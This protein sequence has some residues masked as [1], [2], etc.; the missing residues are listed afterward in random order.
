MDNTEKIKTKDL[1]I[2]PNFVGPRWIRDATFFFP[3]TY[4]GSRTNTDNMHLV[5]IDHEY[6]LIKL[7]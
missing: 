4:I 2:V 1:R 7:C 3:K 5:F 6:T